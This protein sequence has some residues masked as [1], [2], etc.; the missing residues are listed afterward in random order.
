MELT[1]I[2]HNKR[3]LYWHPESS[4]VFE[5][6][7]SEMNMEIEDVTDVPKYQAIFAAS[8]L[9][10]KSSLSKAHTPER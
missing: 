7:A 6:A 8:Q 1:K 4:S 5:G 10:V 3:R 9:V 2:D